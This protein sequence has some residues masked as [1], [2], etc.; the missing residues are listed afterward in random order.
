MRGA[1]RGFGVDEEVEFIIVEYWSDN[2]RAHEVHIG[3]EGEDVWKF[4]DRS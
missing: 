4:S 2:R 1:V 3:E